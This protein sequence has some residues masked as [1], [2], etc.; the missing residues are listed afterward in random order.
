MSIYRLFYLLSPC[1]LICF[2]ILTG[3]AAAQKADLVIRNGNIYT[4]DENK[5]LG[6]AVAVI[7]GKIAFVGS[8][9]EAKNLIGPQTEVLDLQGKTMIPGFIES[10]GHIISLGR[11]KMRLD[12]NEVN[13]YA[14]LVDLVA[15]AVKEAKPGQWILGRGW[16]Q[17]KWEPQPNPM[18]RGFQ[19]HHALSRVS[20]N[21]PVYL[22]H[23]SGHA[24]LAN[25]KAMEIA[26]ITPLATFNDQGEI[27]RDDQGNPTGI[28][29]E[30]AMS[31][32]GKHIPGSSPDSDR[33]ALELAIE[34]CL[35]NGLTSFR[36]AGSDR[37]AIDVYR[38]FL[39][40]GKLKIR[41]WVMLDGQDENL[42][43]EWSAKGPEIGAGNNFL[44]IR[45]I[46]L[47]ADGALGSRGAWLLESY[48]DRPE[49]TGHATISMENVYQVGKAGL[50]HGFQVCVHAIGDRANREVLDQFEKAF[51][52]NPEAAKD[53][54][55]R[56]E[57][58]QHISAGDIP[59]FARLGVIASMQGIHMSSDR[60]WAID[61]LGQERI[62]EGAYVW[63]KLLQSGATIINGTDVPVEPV[64]P[65]AC[66]Y[67]SVTRRTL[68]GFPPDGYEPKQKMTRRQALRSYTLDAAYA[69]FEEDI[70]GSIE[71]GKVADF[72]VFSQDIMKVAEDKLL[73]TIVDYTI[74]EGKIVYK[75]N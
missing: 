69:G 8:D 64:S 74:I 41:L 46:K 50:E 45:A 15:V 52:E 25:A 33:Q 62:I 73:E 28:F 38:E 63:Q 31:L 65:I 57:H 60:P 27:I 37:E 16:H 4:L 9:R 2:L 66:F 17:S 43:Q 13:N 36:D 10:H 5:P 21:N 32:I 23:A 34:E 7:D 68:D 22:S 51:N 20:P 40:R 11:A 44:T 14:E 12:L 70:K 6:E 35:S 55:F 18:V 29:T 19:T 75:R 42:R 56:I 72:T 53:H 26:A 61:R 49:H 58:A 47:V 71:V 3:Y 30:Q 1:F 39:D 59:R 24:G 48:S 67:A 54:R